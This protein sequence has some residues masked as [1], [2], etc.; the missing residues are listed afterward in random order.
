MLAMGLTKQGNKLAKLTTS[1]GAGE[2]MR[3]VFLCRSE[4]LLPI[5]T[6]SLDLRLHACADHGRRSCGAFCVLRVKSLP[7]DGSM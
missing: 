3:L 1:P 5:F 4:V 2:R 6:W 7:N